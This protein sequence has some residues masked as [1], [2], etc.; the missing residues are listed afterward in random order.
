M[1]NHGGTGGEPTKVVWESSGKLSLIRSYLSGALSEV[2]VGMGAS[3]GREAAPQRSGAAAADALASK[4]GLP[5]KQRILLIACGAG[6]G[7]AAVYNAPLAGALFALE[8]YLGTFSLL[9]AIPALLASAVA[10]WV[11]WIALP[12]HAVYLV[13]ILP[14]PTLSLMCFAVVIGPVIGLASSAYVKLIGWVTEHQPKGYLLIVEPMVVFTLFGIVAIRYPL[15]L[16]N[17][18][19]L[20][21]FAFVGSAGV[22]VMLALTFLKP[23]STAACLGSGATGGLLTPTL[24]FGAI[25][26]ALAG[27]LWGLYWPGSPMT[28]YAIIGAAAMLAAAA[29]GPFMGAIFVLELTQ[30]VAADLAPIMLAIGGATLVSRH[31]DLRSIYT[32][33]LAPLS[34]KDSNDA[35][36][37]DRR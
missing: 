18:L 8:V 36:P 14:N 5:E 19:D 30:N 23:I 1:R 26:G 3:L 4:F 25:F 6:A 20:A 24:S 11:A 37:S 27:H 33:R 31:F 7:I 22:L 34:L 10:T 9:L 17:G 28:S 32:A 16:G 13:P 15:L 21:Q 2:T 12:R 35:K 29:Q